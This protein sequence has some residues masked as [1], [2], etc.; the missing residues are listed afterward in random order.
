MSSECKRC[1]TQHMTAR[2]VVRENSGLLIC[3][4]CFT[5]YPRRPIGAWQSGRSLYDIQRTGER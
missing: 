3:P 1:A 4:N 2:L 5:V